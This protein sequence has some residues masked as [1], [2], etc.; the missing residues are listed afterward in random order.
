[1]EDDIFNQLI[2][3]NS[4]WRTNKVPD[5]L[6]KDFK[7]RDFYKLKEQLNLE[8]IKIV[9]GP[10]RVGK[11]STI[12]QLIHHLLQQTNSKNIF[13]FSL[14]RPY[15]SLMDTPIETSIDTFLQRI[16]QKDIH[17]L[18]ETVY[19]F[20]DEIQ[21][22]N[23]WSQ[24]LKMYYDR[25]YNIKFFVTGSSAPALFNK[26]SESLT[27]RAIER[28]MLTL[29]YR[30]VVLFKERDFNLDEKIKK[31]LREGIVKSLETNEI[32]HLRNSID[33]FLLE[34]DD[35]K[36]TTYQTILQ[37]YFLKGGYPE[38]YEK[39]VSFKKLKELIINVYFE[40]II[41]KDIM[42]VFNVKNYN[43]LKKTYLFCS[44]DTSST[45]TYSSLSRDIN[46]PQKEVEE[47]IDY[48]KKTY[49]LNESENFRNNIRKRG[50]LK[51]IFVQDVG[52]RNALLE[53]NEEDFYSNPVLQGIIAETIAND[54]L[55]RLQ[56]S[57]DPVSFK[58]GFFYRGKEKQE[59]DCIFKYNSI[60]IPIEIKYKNKYD[61]SELKGLNDF[62][63][64]FE[65]PFGLVLTKNTYKIS[66]NIL[67][68]PLWIFL[69]LC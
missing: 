20:I 15:Y 9:I 22:I 21:S 51:K 6:L 32:S 34:L 39:N 52:M 50:D 10:R 68:I 30:D 26:S 49:L 17:S 57:L 23:N 27:G 47:Y 14:D 45:F 55:L 37:E 36:K 53:D 60:V 38:F 18:N 5:S 42:Q 19:I 46:I 43:N 69:L 28:T 1:M 25:G 56:F 64:K 35:S 3:E 62:M 7:R 48:L 4:W 41:S 66:D 44:K 12:Y 24:I 2:T 31:Q 67:H 65:S 40:K 63:N 13:Y 33:L 29:K 61:D 54:H 8:Y 16:L 11:T 58:Q 59:V